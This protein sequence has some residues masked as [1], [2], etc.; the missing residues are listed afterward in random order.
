MKSIWYIDKFS[1]DDID[2]KLIEEIKIKQDILINK[3]DIIINNTDINNKITNYTIEASNNI[4]NVN[5]ESKIIEKF[6]ERLNDPN[7]L[8]DERDFIIG[9]LE[10]NNNQSIEY[11]NKTNNLLQK[12]PNWHA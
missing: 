1:T 7:I 9:I 12:I 6:I 11:L 5:E 4:S 2:N 8:P 10:K 3:Q